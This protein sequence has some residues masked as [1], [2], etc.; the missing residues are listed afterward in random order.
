[1]LELLI[2][3]ATASICCVYYISTLTRDVSEA[4]MCICYSYTQVQGSHKS[5]MQLCYSSEM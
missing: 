1:M 5:N 4:Q 2:L 3:T